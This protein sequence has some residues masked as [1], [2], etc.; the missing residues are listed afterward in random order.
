M[1]DLLLKTASAVLRLSRGIR[2]VLDKPLEQALGLDFTE[3]TAL[4][5]IEEGTH[6]PSE[7]SREMQV[8]APTVSRILNHLVDLGLV[9]RSVDQSNLR[10][11][12]LRLTKQGH[13]TRLKTR[14][15][16]AQV[17]REHYG[18]VPETVLSNALASLDA[19]EPH[20]KEA[21][22]A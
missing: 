9:E 15:I 16:V 6:S 5:L 4:R 17:L 20:L 8:P 13:Q 7:L 11:F 14:Q 2:A 3:L 18:H 22:Y 19:L 10:R 1:E 21:R 12:Q